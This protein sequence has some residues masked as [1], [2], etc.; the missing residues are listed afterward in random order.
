MRYPGTVGRREVLFT[1]IA[2]VVT[3]WVGV[4]QAGAE[5][6]AKISPS[7]QVSN[8]KGQNAEVEEAVDHLYVYDLWM[9]CTWIGFARSTDG[10]Q[11]F[12]PSLTVPGSFSTTN[13]DSFAWDP[14]ITVG[15]TGVVYAAFMFFN[16]DTQASYPVVAASFDHGAS[17]TQVSSL[18][19]PPFTDPQGNWGDRDF[20]AVSPDGTVY[21][22]WDYGPSYSEVQFVCSPTGSCGFSAGD[23]NVV[24]QKSKDGGRTWS[25]V[26]PVSPGFPI[27]GADL[28]PI[29]VQPDGTVDVLYQRYPTQPGTLALRPGGEYF[30]RSFDA[31]QTWSVPIRI[32]EGVGTE[33]LDEWW[34]DSSLSTDSAGNL[35]ATWDT[36]GSTSDVGWLSYST[37]G[38]ATWTPAIRVTPR[39][40]NTEELVEVA[41]AGPGIADVA[42]QTPG[43]PQGYAT[44]LRPF[45]IRRGW[46]TASP[47][48]VSDKFGDANIWPGDTFGLETLDGGPD[49]FSGG[50]IGPPVVLS[51]GS[52]VNGRQRSEIFSSVVS[53]GRVPP[54]DVTAAPPQ[55]AQAGGVT[56][57]ETQP[58]R[59]TRPLH[60]R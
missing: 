36:Q 46:L 31:G 15:P 54:R 20:I 44:Y 29:V 38:G 37:D 48:Q 5:P 21:V 34:I 60:F 2:V 35:Y 49:P 42:W 17:F 30:T 41:G 25:R 39:H 32:G 27:G 18:P 13:P 10:G 28:A 53:L 22:T 52:A 50:R 40:G 8:C 57:V 33:S 19:V 47:L 1:L 12:G 23:L 58:P 6:V 59:G 56:T 24:I 14:A 4:A 26:H 3:A 55:S 45:S 11:S 51:W 16:A 7:V 9:G 43:A